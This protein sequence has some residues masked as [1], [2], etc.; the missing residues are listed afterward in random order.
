LLKDELVKHGGNRRTGMS[1]KQISLIFKFLTTGLKKSQAFAVIFC[2]LMSEWLN[3][4]LVR[5]NFV[6]WSLLQW[7]VCK[8]I[9]LKVV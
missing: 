3:V 6:L 1:Q 4:I 5:K 7:S 8:K 2:T 9:F